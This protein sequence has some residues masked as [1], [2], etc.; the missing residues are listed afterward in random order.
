[1]AEHLTALILDSCLPHDNM[2]CP[3]LATLSLIQ[4]TFAGEVLVEVV[5]SRAPLPGV[6]WENRCLQS[7]KIQ[8]EFLRDTCITDL[9][10]ISGTCGGRL[11][12]EWLGL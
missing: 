5:K 3:K 2:V 6:P 7:V 9:E 4:E 12:L 8:C 10:V 1:M 11:T